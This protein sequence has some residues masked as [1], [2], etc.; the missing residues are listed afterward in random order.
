MTPASTLPSLTEAYRLGQLREFFARTP[1]ELEAALD[2][3]RDLDRPALAEA[4]RSYHH[5]LGLLQPGQK[6]DAAGKA[7]A[8]QLDLL[9]HPQARVVVA[10]Q[11][12]GLLGGPAYSV[13]KAAD[14][15]LLARQLSTEARP[16]LPVFW[17]ASQDH[18]VDEVASTSLLDFS[19]REFRPHLE[20]PRGVP[21]G[22]IAWQAAW[23]E[24]LLALLGE[25]DAP[26]LHKAAVRAHL[27]F[28]FQGKTY[29]D[30]FARLMHRL[31]GEHGLMV[32]DPLHPALS[33]LMAPALRRE[34][35]RPLEG[36]QRIEAAA[37]Q[38]EARGYTPQLRRPAGA[39]NLFVEEENGQRTLL[40]VAGDSP[41][42]QHFDGYSHTELLELL[43]RD[44]GRLTPAAG[45]RPVVQDALLPTAAFVV[46][47]GELAYAAELRGVY[48]LH[49]L[50]QPVLW[51]RLS[52]T[53]LEPNVARLLS[54]FGLTAAQF[55]R[56]PEGALGRALAR[57]R[58]AAALGQERLN[59]LQAHF[60]DLSRDLAALDP[61]LKSSV[62]RTEKRTL[63]RLERH[64]TQAFKALARAEDDRSGQ[65]AR[66]KKHLLPAGHPQE[67]EMNFLTFLLK[68]GDAPLKLLLQQAPGTQVELTIP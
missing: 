45:L 11:Q 8:A 12:A 23:S 26:L 6:P 15:V 31:L 21:V 34:L 22:R 59:T 10:G 36:P 47:P 64:R 50:T 33:R 54:G 37:Q 18:D 39:T 28:A 40:R 63:A 1:D 42:S 48:E 35:E 3:T 24:Q 53:W 9:A 61:T 65:L 32:L 29:A 5:D 43:E 62:E 38:L 14:A 4:L 68:H 56:D 55:Q 67:R 49:G 44:P 60:T 16:V 41:R 57:Q 20:L 13:H 7:L 27:D 58:D 17:I 66:L 30:V 46:G 2:E 52:V 25:F 51:P 19:E